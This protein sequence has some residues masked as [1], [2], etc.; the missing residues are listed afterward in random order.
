M[1]WLLVIRATFYYEYNCFQLNILLRAPTNLNLQPPSSFSEGRESYGPIYSLFIYG[2][3][4]SQYLIGSTGTGRRHS[5]A[6]DMSNG[7]MRARRHSDSRHPRP[8]RGMSRDR[9]R[10]R[11]QEVMGKLSRQERI[12]SI[13]ESCYFISNV[14]V[15]T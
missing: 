15:P 6:G 11:D 1:L 5:N 14:L 9:D 10:D 2:L 8:P 13:S 3:G 12:I 4:L 7:G